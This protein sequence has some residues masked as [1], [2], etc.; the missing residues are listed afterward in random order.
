M[1]A[2]LISAVTG[3]D[4]DINCKHNLR[5]SVKTALH[6]CPSLIKTSLVSGLFSFFCRA[7]LCGK[8]VMSQVNEMTFSSI[9]FVNLESY[10]YKNEENFITIMI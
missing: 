9:P 7:K 4:D 1:P 10:S 8:F 5:S 2:Y 3:C 6:L